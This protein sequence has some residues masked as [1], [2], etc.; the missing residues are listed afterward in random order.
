VSDSTG[1]MLAIGGI[2]TFNTW[3]V[4]GK[5]FPWRPLVATGIAAGCLTLLEKANHAIAMGLAWTA[6]ITVLFVRLRPD[7]PAP[8]EAFVTWWEGT[9][10]TTASG[11]FVSA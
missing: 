7:V 10:G 2:T 3:I 1:P 9:P 8:V 6:L 4:A 5:D 11:P